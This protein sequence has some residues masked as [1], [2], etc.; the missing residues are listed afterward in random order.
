MRVNA[1]I[2][3]PPTFDSLVHARERQLAL[4]RMLRLLGAAVLVVIVATG[5][6]AH[7]HPAL[8]GRGLGVLLALV[9]LVA[10]YAILVMDVMHVGM[11]GGSA[12][13]AERCPTRRDIAVLADGLS[14]A[15]IAAQLV[16]AEA[17]V[18]SHVNHLF[19]KIGARDRAQAVAY[20]Y[21]NGLAPG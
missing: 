19:A 21:R 2:P 12:P 8:S 18:K 11:S 3:A 4:T 5:F 10:C 6:S 16:V 13:P 9:A 14:N 7:P 1:A 20:A 15:E 17:T